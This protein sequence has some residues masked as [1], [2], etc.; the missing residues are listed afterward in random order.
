MRRAPGGFMGQPSGARHRTHEGG[1]TVATNTGCRRPRK[2]GHGLGKSAVRKKMESAQ[3]RAKQL[4][5]AKV[6]PKRKVRPSHSQ[7]RGQEK[8][9]QQRRGNPA[10]AAKLLMV[11]RQRR[12]QVTGGATRQSKPVGASAARR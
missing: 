12:N 11:C 3:N 2:G 7:R 1:D 6:A 8:A 9:A 5:Q 4:G 10:A